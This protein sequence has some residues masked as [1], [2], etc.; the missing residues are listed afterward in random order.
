MLTL[1]TDFLTG[2]LIPFKALGVFFVRPKYWTYALVPTIISLV[3][4]VIIGL[5]G[6]Y[7][8]KPYID[9]LLPAAVD[10]SGWLESLKL[11]ARWLLYIA[12]SLAAITVFLITFTS[13]FMV[14]AAPFI[15][16]LAVRY[17]KDFYNLDFVC[18]GFKHYIHYNWTSMIN[19]A[20][21]G[22]IILVLTIVFIIFNLIAPGVGYILS[23]LVI[24]Y[25]FGVS[26]LIF[27]SEHRRVKYR[28]FKA[29]LKGSKGLITGMGVVI[30][31]M[32]FIPF[33]PVIFLP[34]S[35]IAGTIVYNDY[36]EPRVK[37]K[38]SNRPEELEAGTDE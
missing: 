23:A 26:F 25:Y 12:M 21:V 34:V 29:N 17:E 7:Y 36:I 20:R 27:S 1:F 22:I 33:L 11:I 16:Q 24:G 30:Y 6:W 37:L 38:N 31:I 3:C 35:V 15:D 4:Y 13:L 5:L 10:A 9:S 8:L 2:L 32:M 19:S 18:T 14:I 28:D